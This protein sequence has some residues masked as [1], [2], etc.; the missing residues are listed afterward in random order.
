MT[1]PNLRWVANYSE[2][3]SRSVPLTNCITV[4]NC[5]I[6]TFFE[7]HAL[8]ITTSH[9]SIVSTLFCDTHI[10]STGHCCIIGD[11]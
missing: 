9:D 10:I 4:W 7:E 5:A 2:R 6:I 1:K 3:I 8:S 11:D